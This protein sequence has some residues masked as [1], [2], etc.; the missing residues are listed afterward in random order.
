MGKSRSKSRVSERRRIKRKGVGR[1]QGEER[2][3]MRV[4]GGRGEETESRS[5]WKIRRE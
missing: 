4:R 2:E 5:G 3:R 1:M